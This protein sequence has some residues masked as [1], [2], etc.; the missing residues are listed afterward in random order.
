MDFHR[1]YTN[2][3]PYQE[4]IQLLK[5]FVTFLVIYLGKGYCV[6]WPIVEIRGQ[7]QGADFL[8]PPRRSLGLTSGGQIQQQV[9]LAAKASFIP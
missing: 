6:S 7:I 2:L 8:L 4:F 5:V 3:H 9:P 1:I